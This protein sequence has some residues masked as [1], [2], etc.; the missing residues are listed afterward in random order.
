MSPHTSQS[1]VQDAASEPLKPNYASNDYFIRVMG[2]GFFA[3]ILIAIAALGIGW[4]PSRDSYFFASVV[5][6]FH[7]SPTTIV[8]YSITLAIGVC[9]LVFTWVQ[10]G[11]DT[12]EG[13]VAS[14]ELQRY[15]LALWSLPLIFV[16]PL[17]SRDVYSYFAHGKLLTLG[18]DPYNASAAEV[19]G[20]VEDGV[21]PLWAH[22]PSPYGQ[23][24]LLIG[25]GIFSA[26]GDDPYL[27]MI[28]FR[29]VALVGVLLLA[30][31]IPILARSCGVSPERAM[32]LGVLNPL[33]ILQFV[34]GI[35]NDALMV[36]MIAAGLALAIR[37]HP[38]WAV[39]VISFAASVKPVALL[40]LPF[41]GAI[42][43]GNGYPK[44]ELLKRWI[45]S[46]LLC[47]A[48]L[49]ALAV[50]TGT[51]FGWLNVLSSPAQVTTWFSP[52]T[53]L[54]MTVGNILE[55]FG[56]SAMSLSV[57]IARLLGLV[58][59]VAL[60]IYLW[61]QPRN[62]EPI[63]A[64]GLGFLILAVLGPTLQIWYLLWSIPF[65]AA[66]AL[67]KI[68]CRLII[69]LTISLSIFTLIAHVYDGANYS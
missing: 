14:L 43:V 48:I 23:F 30:W 8:A 32:W 11:F 7:A 35:H 60:V 47:G 51:G 2:P 18:L 19:G 3:S 27:S 33:I 65:L 68:E 41:V 62:R 53:A 56:I 46:G 24:F 5:D 59:A 66:S 9:L 20:W 44:R 34:A 52:P 1:G 49:I 69:L 37:K 42:W 50:I 40:A 15:S 63:R 10:L 55:A 12:H 17:F 13:K 38:M 29:I 36:G 61:H 57:S 4:I 6:A 58:A 22:A 16:P 45:Q 28:M 39:V 25:R 31:A 64:V 21:D 67:S 26:S 54:G